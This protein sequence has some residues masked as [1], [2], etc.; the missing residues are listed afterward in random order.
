MSIASHH[1][2]TIFINA[3]TSSGDHRQRTTQDIAVSEGRIIGL[4]RNLSKDKALASGAR[5]IDCRGG[6][7]L[8]GFV[9]AHLH[10]FSYADTLLSLDLRSRTGI[11]SID[12]IQAALKREAEV[13]PQ[14]EWIKGK[15]YN[16]FYLDEKRH[17]NR[18]DLD[19]AAPNHPVKLTHR[20]RHAHALN[21][22][23]LKLLGIDRHTPDPPGGMIDR[24]VPSGEPTGL[25][26]EMGDLLAQR[27]PRWSPGRFERAAARAARNLASLGI[28]AFVDASPHNDE[29]RRKQFQEYK[30]KGLIPQRVV[31][32][33]GLEGMRNLAQP[34]PPRSGRP[35]ADVP[36]WGLKLMLD[37]TT[38]SLHP[39]Q[40]ELNETVL[41]AQ[42]NGWAAAI[43]AVEEETI[44]AALT[45]Y[46]M[47]AVHDRRNFGRRIEHGSICPPRLAPRM[48]DIGVT[49][50]TQPSFLY[51]F[52]E[53]YLATID[54]GK[55]PHLYP[56]GS[57]LRHGV[58]VAGSSDCPL[59]PPSPL[60]GVYA[61]VARRADNGRFVGQAHL[62]Q[63]LSVEEAIDLY[64]T[65][66]S[67]A[68]GL[69][70]TSGS[71]ATGKQADL[72][73]LSRHPAAGSPESI[74]DI[75]VLLTMVGGKIVW[76][77]EG[78]L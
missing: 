24:E 63:R 52:G 67:R 21:S 20:S 41:E 49:V 73:V 27:I 58:P 42:K 37:R 78:A 5:I 48:A 47:A 70:T 69:E 51:Y 66:A 15:G 12:H 1:P 76:E 45:A 39:S 30:T 6:A 36:V 64:T 32:M 4:D 55:L 75:E 40:A 50:T 3:E 29:S 60:M 77:R 17:P 25:F 59:V 57:W 26:Y 13:A 38:G 7:V 74:R 44:E 61:A 14:G 54:P 68:A 16:E 34:G 8:P 28:T 53:R 19:T 46:E 71:L 62:D 31:M 56:L 43:H 18:W 23:A 65:N 10:F 2:V 35:E 11:R 22:L 9:D 72:I 33:M